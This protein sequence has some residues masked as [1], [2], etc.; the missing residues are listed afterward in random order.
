MK[1]KK[2]TGERLE[3]FVFNQT[4]IEHL[5]RYSF[6]IDL[7]RGKKVLDIASGSGY[8][9]N[10]LSEFAESV[11]GIDIDQDSIYEASR[12]YVKPNLKF[13]QGSVI[14]IPISDNEFD[15]V[16]SFE[17][18]EHLV[19]HEQMLTELTRVL[20]PEGIL[21]I[22]SPDKFNYSVKPNSINIHH[23]KELFEAEFKNL[24]NSFFSFTKFYFQNIGYLSFI[25]GEDENLNAEMSYGDYEQIKAN[26]TLEPLYWIC[27]ASNSLLI[28]FKYDS[29]FNGNFVLN[30]IKNDSE[31]SITSSIEYRVG[32]ILLH[33]MTLFSKIK[34]IFTK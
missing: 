17:T 18:I 4:T 23:R 30:S 15:V 24:I 31:S 7:V 32:Y 19:E 3:T 2:W 21:I 11:V 8:G 13:I 16:I 20:K 5:H 22:S 33:P 27:V 6:C 28:D 9:S 14:E 26:N 10:I 29:F 1:N 34:S 12:K 25:K